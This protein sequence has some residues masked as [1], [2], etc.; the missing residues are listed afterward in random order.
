MAKKTTI[1]PQYDVDD[2]EGLAEH[3]IKFVNMG[4]LPIW[5][6]EI[7]T[8][9]LVLMRVDMSEPELKQHRG[10]RIL[11]GADVRSFIM[12]VEDEPEES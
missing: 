12:A 1:R 3:V 8:A 11:Y 7:A 4:Y 9:A 6:H 10:T 5:E 2:W